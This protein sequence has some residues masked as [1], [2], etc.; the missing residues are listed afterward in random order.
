VLTYG[1]EPLDAHPV[2]QAARAMT[3]DREPHWLTL[4]ALSRRLLTVPAGTVYICENPAVISYAAERELAGVTLVCSSG[5]PNTAVAKLARQLASNGCPLRAQGDFDWEGV[6]IHRHLVHALGA[7]PWRFDADT[8][9][10]GVQSARH[11]DDDERR[12]SDDAV[13]LTTPLT[14]AMFDA[15][16]AVY[17]EDVCELLAGDLLEPAAAPS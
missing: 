8:Y 2:A 14:R 7:R 1:L 16:V 6:R 13:A 3:A 12:L 17:E 5:W 4:R 10:A 9:Q 15:G 11:G